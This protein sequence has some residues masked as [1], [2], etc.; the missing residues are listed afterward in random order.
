MRGICF[1]NFSALFFSLFR[2]QITEGW[3]RGA[4]NPIRSRMLGERKNNLSTSSNIQSGLSRAHISSTRHNLDENSESF[5][6]TTPASAHLGANSVI[7]AA[8][9]RPSTTFHFKDTTT[10]SGIERRFYQSLSNQPK[11]RPDSG[12]RRP[13]TTMVQVADGGAR[14]SVQHYSSSSE[15]LGTHHPS[16]I[17]SEIHE[18]PSCQTSNSSSC[19]SG[20]TPGVARRRWIHKAVEIL[21]HQTL[22]GPKDVLLA[23][24]PV[25]ASSIHPR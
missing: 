11:A 20:F 22:C 6:S 2:C 16:S 5:E 8:I 9:S 15:D 19:D 7:S 25:D 23:Q 1:N 3:H 13:L 24:L 14:S 10:P 18:T 4:S 21:R 17:E 12:I